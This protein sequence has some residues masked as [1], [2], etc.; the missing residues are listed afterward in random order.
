MAVWHRWQHAEQAAAAIDS[1]G[2]MFTDGRGEPI[3]PHA[4]SQSFERTARRAQVRVIRL[5]DL[6]HTHGTLLITAGFPSRW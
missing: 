6:R 1:A 3:H 4:I 2:W 5:H